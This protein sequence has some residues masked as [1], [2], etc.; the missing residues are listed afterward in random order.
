MQHILPAGFY[1]FSVDKIAHLIAVHQQH[2]IVF[3]RVGKPNLLT[4]SLFEQTLY[5]LQPL[6]IKPCCIANKLPF[7]VGQFINIMLQQIGIMQ[8]GDKVFVDFRTVERIP[9][10]IPG[11]RF[12]L[13][14]TRVIGLR[15]S[16][17]IGLIRLIK[18]S[19]KRFRCSACASANR[20]CVSPTAAKSAMR[21]S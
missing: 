21:S 9:A 16:S 10:G 4:V 5:V 17:L 20:P 12:G 6:L 14:I 2:R 13:R 3:I 11:W 18:L 7:P 1:R 19:A 15:L 8:I